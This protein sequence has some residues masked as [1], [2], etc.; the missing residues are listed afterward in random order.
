MVSV[1][2]HAGDWGLHPGWVKPKTLKL[3]FTASPLNTQYS[4][5]RAKTD[6][7][8]VSIMCPSGVTCLPADYYFSV[9]AL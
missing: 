5:V 4:G 3:V 2:L 9:L 6:R 1:F 8:G 7:L